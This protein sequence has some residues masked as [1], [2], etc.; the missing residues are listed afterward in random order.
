MS[1]STE[2]G[3]GPE[4]GRQKARRVLDH[5][6]GATAVE[7]GF[8]LPIIVLVVYG[9]VEF[10]RVLLLQSV[11]FFAAEEATRFATVRYDATTEEIRQIAENKLL[12]A[13][14]SRITAFNVVSDLN[15]DDQTKLVTVEIAYA[16]RPLTPIGWGE[17]TL[18]GHSRG[19]IVDK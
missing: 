1:V 14:P 4:A 17:T 2:S 11:L 13:D 6:G 3:R 7:F 8:V 5:D 10:A 19:F 12:I 9:L 16:F 18:L 15:P